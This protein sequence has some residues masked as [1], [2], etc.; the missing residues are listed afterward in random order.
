MPF[1]KSTYNIFTKPWEDEVWDDN[2]MDSDT[3]VLPPKKDWDYSRELT[4]SD[5][6]LWEVI[7]QKSGG[8]GIYASW[9][10]YAEFYMITDRFHTS[11]N[12]PHIRT[13]YGA[14]AIHQVVDVMKQRN[15]PFSLQKYWVDE[16]KMWL[17]EEPESIV[18]KTLILP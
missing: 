1:F 8:I 9:D 5:V 6:S 18:A 12:D 3:L 2:W 11:Q 4:I 17:Y 14:G 15:I 16:D 10:P 13:F 7:Y